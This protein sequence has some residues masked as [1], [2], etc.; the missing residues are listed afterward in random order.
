MRPT[1]RRRICLTLAITLVLAAAHSTGQPAGDA[2]SQRK[3]ALTLEQQGKNAEAEAVWRLYLK[4]H[5]SNPEPYAHLGLLEVHQQHYAEAVRL[6]RKALEVGPPMPSVR[7]NLGL[8]LFKSGD[9]TGAIAEFEPLLK[10]QPDNLQLTTLI[11]MAHYQLAAYA[12]AVPYLRKAAA[13]DTRN[14][15]LRL[16]LAHSCLWSGQYQ[17][18]VDTSKEILSMNAESAEA[19]M[20]VGEALDGMKDRNGAIA[21]FRAALKVNPRTPDAHF[22]LGYLLWTLKQFPEAASEFQ[23][24]LDNNPNHAQA[25]TYLA[26]VDLQTGH[27]EAALPLLEKAIKLNSELELVHLDLGILYAGAGRQDDAL[28]EMKEAERLDPA[29]VNVHWR[30]GRLYRTMGKK[31]ESKTEFDKASQINKMANDS[32]LGKIDRDRAHPPQAQPPAPESP[33]K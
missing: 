27:D 10:S 20:L 7:L 13:L 15:P 25:M 24:E 6:Y 1:L 19:D 17:C 29:D 30:L 16:A 11:G 8:A 2:A 9:Y 31:D 14:M 28:R 18:V 23:A 21:Q 33:E 5:P 4:A 3:T 22:S 12:Q 26:D 32:L